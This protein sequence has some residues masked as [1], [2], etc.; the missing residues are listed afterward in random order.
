MEIKKI[1][2]NLFELSFKLSHRNFIYGI[3][4]IRSKNVIVFNNNNYNKM[5]YRNK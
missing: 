1:K 2:C 3:N 5:K 4:L